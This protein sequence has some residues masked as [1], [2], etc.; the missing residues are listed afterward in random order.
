M[1]EVLHIAV[2]GARFAARFGGWHVPLVVE[3]PPGTL[4][5]WTLS[6]HLAALA[7]C[8]N[9][10]LGL[11]AERLADEVLAACWSGAPDPALRPLA[12]WWAAGAAPDVG[13]E[14]RLGAQRVRLRPWSH[15]ARLAALEAAGAA[16]QPPELDLGVYLEAQVRASVEVLGPPGVDPSEL[17]AG[18]VLAAVLAVN[19]PRP[20]PALWGARELELCAALGMSPRQLLALPAAELDEALLLLGRP[21]KA[22][23]PP[24]APVGLAAHPD[25]TTIWFGA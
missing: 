15:G 11:D 13:A 7:R 2:D 18:L 17:P 10:V 9:P 5:P 8:V 1:G 21:R 14:L 19:R 16:R 3:D 24:P 6:A 22:P 25:T 20:L 4:A 12:L 23:S